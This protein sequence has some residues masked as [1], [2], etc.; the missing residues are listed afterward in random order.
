MRI[1]ADGPVFAPSKI[2]GTLVTLMEG[3]GCGFNGVSGISIES[4]GG[5]LAP[6]VDLPVDF[7]SRATQLQS[8]S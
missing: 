3:S 8:H 6:E 5:Q 1:C 7:K 4:G 2:Q